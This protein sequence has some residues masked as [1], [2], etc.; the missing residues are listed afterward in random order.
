MMRARISTSSRSRGGF[1]LI[2]LMIAITILSYGILTMTLM[3]LTALKQGGA[4]RHT[5]DAAAIGRTYLEQVHRLPWVALT[6]V[7]DVGWSDPAWAGV[8]SSVDT[9]VNAPSGGLMIE[10][11]Y[12]VSWQVSTIA[13]TA[14]MLDVEMRVT[15]NE[16]GESRQKSLTLATRRYNW[17]GASC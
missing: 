15:W 12:A 11:S 6:A 3:Q 4:G 10:N 2:E 1:S 16:A 7:Q 17:G 8:R 5:T 14:C 13:T 9:A